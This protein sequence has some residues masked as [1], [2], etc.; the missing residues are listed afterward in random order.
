MRFHEILEQFKWL[1]EMQTRRMVVNLEDVEK[2]LNVIECARMVISEDG[3]S[4]GKKA[5]YESLEE[6]DKDDR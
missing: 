1:K 6:L 2:M 3:S 4:P 5:L